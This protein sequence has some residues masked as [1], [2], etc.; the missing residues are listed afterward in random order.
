MSAEVKP[1]YKQTE[2]GV[3][4]EDWDAKVIGH[5]ID[6]LTGFPF[7]SSGYSDS[8]IRLLRGSNV[9]RGKTVW[10]DD[11]TQYWPSVT[12]EIS[13]YELRDGDLVIAMDGSLVG[14][15]SAQLTSEDL[16]ALLL[17]RVA[18]IRSSKTYD[19][20][21]LAAFVKSDWFI[22]HSDAVKTVTAIPH[23]SPADIRT[24]MIPAPPTINEQRAIAIALSDMETLINGLDQLIAKK[25]DIQQAAMQ[26]L[27]T[28]QRRLPGFSGEWGVKRL[29][30]IGTF[31][32][33]SG[34]TRDQSSSGLLPCVRY[35]EIYTA[36]HNL[37]RA[38]QSLI[39]KEVA[40]SATLLKMGDLL[41]AGSGETKAEIG[42]CV[43]F[44]NNFEAY[45]GGDIVILRPISSDSTFLGYALNTQEICRQKASRGQG[46]AVVHISANA[47]STVEIK[48][49][50]K[51]EQTAIATILTEM[52][53]ELATL[54]ARREKAHQLKQGM[55][56][57]LLT[58][59][60][61]LA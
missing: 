37:V 12:P 39:S 51:D 6:L 28:G 21:Y 53:T 9:K 7:P 27:L 30:E 44:V 19:V 45:A 50:P 17:Q 58:G 14:R 4:P 34:V 3:I 35:G 56:Q 31:M 8:G 61:R 22:K 48:L 55:M 29:G 54:E 2:A 57:E 20:G 1:G 33:G 25:R 52:D 11:I 47:L 60:I 36:H 42:K 5:D 46:D 24:F 10:T 40:A 32:K 41:F 38:F 26:Q 13:R 23:I 49:P 15:S 43:A 18:R 16:P 59:R